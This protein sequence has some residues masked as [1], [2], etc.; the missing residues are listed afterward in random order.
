[1]LTEV[2]LSAF[3]RFI[4]ACDGRV[5]TSESVRKGFFAAAWV[6]AVLTGWPGL[7]GGPFLIVTILVAFAGWSVGML[8]AYPVWWLMRRAGLHWSATMALGALMAP[9]AGL[10]LSYWVWSLAIYLSAVGALAGLTFWLVA[11]RKTGESAVCA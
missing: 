3:Q 6:G 10:S 2:A 1:M 11:Y 7:F 8:L 9:L 5:L 4:H